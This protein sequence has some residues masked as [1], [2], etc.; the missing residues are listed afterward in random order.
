M[1]LLATSSVCAKSGYR[2]K[3]VSSNRGTV[4]SYA[5][6]TVADDKT[7]YE[8][9]S[10]PQNPRMTLRMTEQ[11]C[12]SDF[13]T[14][15]R[16]S[17][18]VLPTGERISTELGFTLDDGLVLT[19]KKGKV[20]GYD[21]KIFSTMMS[22]NHY[23][24]WVTT[25]LRVKGTPQMGIGVPNGLV[26]KV[27]KNG[28][29][30]EEAESITR[31]KDMKD[32]WLADWGSMLSRHD[33]FYALKQSVVVTVPIFD[34]VRLSYN[35]AVLPEG[36]LMPDKVYECGGG[37][38]VLKK[39]KLPDLSKGYGIFAE[40]TQY[41]EG[42]AYDR[43]GSIFVIPTGKEQSF[44]DAIRNLNSTPKFSSGGVDYH[45]LVSTPTYD[46]PAEMMRFFTGFG[47]HY[48][49]DSMRIPGQQWADSVF[50]KAQVTPLQ[51]LLHGEVWI[52]AYIGNWDSRGHCLSLRLKYFPDDLRH[53]LYDYDNAMPL[54]NTVNYL[55]QAEQP[56]PEFQQ[57]DSLKVKF[58][59]DAPAKN[60][61][62]MY[63]T[64]GHGGWGG[65]D[66][67]NQKPNTIYLDGQ[68]VISFIPWRDD[69]GTYRNNNPQS[70]VYETGCSSSD[71]SRSNW[72]PGTVTNP[73]FIPLGSL[74]AGE[75]TIEVN[76]PQGAPV[77]GSKSYWCVS[78][79]LLY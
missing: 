11:K 22:S 70:G 26:L 66:E 63:I 38:V 59:L 78:G 7:V 30:V 46:V 73:N 4:T 14:L 36:E 79:T 67:F 18:A 74:S 16:V 45:G 77:A 56:Y 48:Y 1:L 6:L 12:Y 20:L 54:F 17:T 15:K 50:Y 60:A 3:Y 41:S 57:N 40:V 76:I 49:N 23:D 69:C 34:K 8:E 64:T 68:K 31:E 39:V 75:H 37:T 71:M 13:K 2:I 55:E 19:N 32:F 72:C 61:K 53:V 24:V 65:G 5:T 27:V 58:T 42:D 51:S 35:D 52:G 9:D 25:D 47:V 29:I 33:Y 28:N 21:C 62:L 10:M 44:I 43:T